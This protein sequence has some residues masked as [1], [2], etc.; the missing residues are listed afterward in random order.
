MSGRE[1]VKVGRWFVGL[2]KEKEI[3]GLALSTAHTLPPGA[4]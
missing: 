3:C 2:G 4:V 1:R